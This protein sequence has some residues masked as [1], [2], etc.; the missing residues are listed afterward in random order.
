MASLGDVSDDHRPGHGVWAG[1]VHV[2]SGT[3]AI[4][5]AV[6]GNVG[7]PIEGPELRFGLGCLDGREN[8]GPA[9]LTRHV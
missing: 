9:L 4:N 2:G 8:R 3:A 6:A 5:R 7:A 1:V